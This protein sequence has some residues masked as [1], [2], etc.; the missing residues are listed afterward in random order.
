MKVL[1]I[2]LE[3]TIYSG[4]LFCA[5]MLI[6]Q[7]FKN[8]MSPFLHLVIWGL[9]IA[10]LLVPVMLESSVHLIVIPA[11]ISSEATQ[12]QTPETN[13][14][15][16]PGYGISG[17]NQ[18]QQ[19]ASAIQQEANAAAPS[20]ATQNAVA[21][22]NAITLSTEEIL[23]AV[24][25][26]GAGIGLLY[27]VALYTL[28]RR[29][30]RKNAQAPSKR[31]L[32]LFTETKAELN[33]RRNVRI[34]GQ[35]EYGT[36]AVLFPNTVL[37]PINT[38][39]SM[40]D[41][42]VKFVLR[43]ELMH[44]KRRDHIFG[45]VLSILN[46]VYWFNPV[47][48]IAFKQIRADMETACDS[49][50]VRVF[51]SDEKTTYAAVILSL[52]SKKQY[53]NLV[54]GM[55]QGNTR[56]IAEKRIRGVFMNRKSNRK[57]KLAAIA[58]ASLLLFTCFTTACQPTPESEIVVGKNNDN[59]DSIIAG[60]PAPTMNVQPTEVW[61]EQLNGTNV[62]INI[63]AAIAF[64]Q[65]AQ[66]PV[67]EAGPK[68]YT[69]D[70]AWKIIKVFF[71]DAAVYDEPI[72]TKEVLEAQI[73]ALK[74]ELA[75]VQS[76]TLDEDAESIQDEIDYYT[77]L[78]QTAPSEDD[79]SQ[80][81][82]DLVF[83]EK[84][85]REIIN[86]SANIGNSGSPATLMIARD[87]T[88]Y[89]STIYFSNLPDTLPTTI[90][91]ENN[92]EMTLDEAVSLAQ[93]TMSD[94]GIEDMILVESNTVGSTQEQAYQLNFIKS[95]N[96]VGIT[97]YQTHMMTQQEGEAS[98]Y[99]P[100]LQAEQATIYIND[101]GVLQ[102]SLLNALEMGSVINENVDTLSLDKVKDIFRDQVFY[103]YYAPDDHPLT[104]NVDRIEL[105]YFIQSVKDQ[106]GVFRAIPVWD[107]L[108]SEGAVEG[109]SYIYSVLTINAIDGS[110]IDR[111]L[112][113]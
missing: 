103:N 105:S 76:G 30:I 51:S 40:R 102:F 50:V 3:I 13:T 84:N 39:V 18:A 112:G 59:L 14:D 60:T 42:E 97:D 107:F 68:L 95:V 69:V 58:L 11:E 28:L 57:V 66:F 86:V 70:D 23:L 10:R 47:V 113:Y 106:P 37:M 62:T 2:L 91:T 82:D 53:G 55:V 65:V 93:S 48:W 15:A 94:L 108:A 12:A 110:V 6:K 4:I 1:N 79:A 7:G 44:F 63:D 73:L 81:I 89:T 8:R 41:E 100:I 96:S 61:Q 20:T 36:P 46:A 56:Q 43:H 98:V 35:C 31:L 104:I 5:I 22:Q 111:N 33:I 27:L 71:Q 75:E 19:Q 109:D 64:P 67:V 34:I 90:T 24:W 101:S 83:E 9:L 54:L 29:R 25:L 88:T 77:E 32:A 16:T 99:A 87:G 45:L 26:T 72:F 21:N 52:F 78:L 38:L 49:D 85:G 17:T 92:M 74:K 80:A